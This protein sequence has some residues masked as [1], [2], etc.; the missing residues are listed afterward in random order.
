MA[1]S[2]T[3]SDLV[4]RI[5]SRGYWRVVIRPV[6]FDPQRVPYADMER[7]VERARVS[8][9]GW[10]VPHLSTRDPVVQLG[11][12]VGQE[13]AWDYHLELWRMYQSGQFL[14]LSSMRE[15]WRDLSSMNPA[16]EGWTPGRHLNV[17]DTL[18]TFGEYYELASRLSLSEAGAEEMII[19]VLLVGLEGRTLVADDPRRAPLHADY[20]TSMSQFSSETPV[21]REVLVASSRDLAAQAASDLFARFRWNPPIDQLRDQLDELWRLR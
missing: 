12:S 14:H 3:Q 13:S 18:W 16:G 7:T 8:L 11:D 19:E 17:T 15:D 2:E 1:T 9:R 6:E 4:A 20:S 10:D 21:S 5:Q